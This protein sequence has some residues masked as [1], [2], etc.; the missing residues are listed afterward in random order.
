M[1]KVGRRA[2]SIVATSGGGID[3]LPGKK[4]Y[5]VASEID[6]EPLQA[7]PIG[8]LACFM[9]SGSES[10]L[11]DIFPIV[12]VAVSDRGH[13][14]LLAI[15][16]HLG[17]LHSLPPIPLVRI[18][19][20]GGGEA[21]LV[22][23]LVTGPLS[24]LASFANSLNAQLLDLKR[25]RDQLFEHFRSLEDA[26]NAQ[27][28]STVSCVFEQQPYSDP[29]DV[30]LGSLLVETG[31]TQLLPVASTGL[32]GFALHMRPTSSGA[33]VLHVSL[34][35]IETDTMVGHW[36]AIPKRV[37]EGWNYFALPRMLS[38]TA[39][40]LRIHLKAD[41]P[42]APEPSLGYF[43]PQAEF[44]AHAGTSHPDLDHRPLAFRLY[45]GIPGVQPDGILNMLATVPMDGA[46]ESITFRM[47]REVLQSAELC[48]QV[49]AG[50]DYT[51]VEYIS[52]E[53]CVL[54]HPQVGGPTGALLSGGVPPGTLW[55]QCSVKLAHEEGKPAYAAM[56][57]ADPDRPLRDQFDTLTAYE[58]E[59]PVRNFSGWAPIEAGGP[60]VT[61]HVEF[62]E[63]LTK[64]HDLVLISAAASDEVAFSWVRF[65]NFSLTRLI[66]PGH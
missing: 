56:M 12:G 9:T 61:L 66:V 26:F 7:G 35:I 3:P 43:L 57:L 37:V 30:S 5:V 60:S 10:R 58:R 17:R 32:A 49:H 18:I 55:I 53:S 36:L 19:D 38:A 14:D 41:G 8:S 1:A 29:Y 21:T 50:V 40:S 20:P 24:R 64:V 42:G 59:E 48:T 44:E 34:E 52:E 11:N 54:C 25:E 23:E 46:P 33:S 16:K 31:I 65:C 47:P 45:A 15:C 27:S 4:R 2:R 62:S 28:M 6:R 63:T 13:E 51:L 22:C 39:H